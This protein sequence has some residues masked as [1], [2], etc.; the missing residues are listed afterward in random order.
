[1]RS[2]V[3]FLVTLAAILIPPLAGHE[4]PAEPERLLR[5]IAFGSCNSP[6]DSTPVWESVNHRRPD[7]WIWLG[8]TV[9]ADSPTPEG[10]TPAARARVSLD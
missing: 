8:D 1:M 10:P 3:P 7:A 5:R 2:L 9:Y 4:A 6:F